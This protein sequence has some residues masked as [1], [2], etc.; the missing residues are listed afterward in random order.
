MSDD[1]GGHAPHASATEYKF[2]EPRHTGVFVCKH[3]A[4]G[5]PILYVCHDDAGD[6]QFLCGSAHADVEGARL[7]CLE[8]VVAADPSLNALAE[9]DAGQLATRSQVRAEWCSE[10]PHERFV[11]RCVEQFGWSVQSID[12]EGAAP[13]F[14]YTIGL[15]QTFQQPELIV[16]GL[17]HEAAQKLLN[18]IGQ[19]IREGQRFV[20]GTSYGGLVDSHDVRFRQVLD[21]TSMRD[22][23]GYA[24]WYYGDTPLTLQQLIWPDAA[25]AFPDAPIAP[26]W[27]QSAQPL[28]P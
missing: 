17:P 5:A 15:Q 22:H 2:H 6:W 28:L 16:F 4:E 18:L 11:V 13:G 14:S 19:R 20:P 7:L 3:V 10:D 23:V 26:A 21:P 9:L 24:L 1:S 8:Q 12:A 25:G 27:L